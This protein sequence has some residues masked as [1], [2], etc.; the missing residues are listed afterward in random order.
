MSRPTLTR[1]ETGMDASIW[2]IF[3]PRLTA[4]VRAAPLS[5]AE[6]GRDET[7]SWAALE[8]SHWRGPAR[9]LLGRSHRSHRRNP[10]PGVELSERRR[11][12]CLVHHYRG[13]GPVH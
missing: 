3:W 10:E 13:A 4:A 11:R 7:R 6:V 9:G 1:Q 12:R 8:A 5:S 2:A